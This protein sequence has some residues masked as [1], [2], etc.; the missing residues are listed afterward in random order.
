MNIFALVLP[1][2]MIV[3]SIGASIVCL[4][5]KQYGSSIYWASAALLNISVVYLIKEFG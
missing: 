2:I 5:A 3:L 4:I 1:T